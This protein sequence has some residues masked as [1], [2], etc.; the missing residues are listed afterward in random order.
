MDLTI[1]R[2]NLIE[3]TL[4]P[5]GIHD[6]R[7]LRAMARIPRHLFVAEGIA[8]KAYSDNA[9]PIGHNQTMSK[10]LVVARMLQGLC[11]Q[12]SDRVLEIGTG[13]AYQT[14]LLAALVREVVSVE[15]IEDFIFP[16]KRLMAR[17]DLYNI[18]ILKAGKIF[19]CPEHA[20]YDAIVISACA[21]KL[22]EELFAQLSA[23]GGR[24]VMPVK[25]KGEQRLRLFTQNGK[26]RMELD[27]GPC[28]FVPLVPYGR[29]KA[30]VF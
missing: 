26:K 15:L 11:L 4:K 20:P 3:K 13:S 18:K 17:L 9:I 22:P 16:A 14:A 6:P 23:D 2:R 12:R 28:T 8:H 27:L 25:I 5:G 29:A 30:A 21:E 24:M 10:P 1:A 7:I 19:G